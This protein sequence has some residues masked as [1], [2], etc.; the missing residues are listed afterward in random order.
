MKT[1][2]SLAAIWFATIS[3]SCTNTMSVTKRNNEVQVRNF[4]YGPHRQH[5]AE[6]NIPENIND[7]PPIVL[8]HGGSWVQG[9]KWMLRPVAKML[10]KQG[11]TTINIDYRLATKK[12][13][14]YDQF[15]DVRLAIAKSKKF[16]GVSDSIKVTLL[17]ES[18]GAQM[19]MMY[20]YKN[21]S[22]IGKIISL[23]G[24]T[25]LAD[26]AYSTTIKKVRAM[27]VL[28]KVTGERLDTKNIPQVYKDLSPYA[29][30]G[31]VPTLMIHG[32]WDMFVNI[33]QAYKLEKELVAKNVPHKLVVIEKAGHVSRL[34]PSVRKTIIYP[35]IIKWLN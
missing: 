5:K 12:I 34:I 20:G 4:S 22:E 19:S 7:K 32:T 3:A 11:F 17:G 35:E 16:L 27:P 6:I 31:D 23:S 26:V 28:K 21:P 33:R 25:D 29:N 24:P 13:C 1:L 30:V 2:Y 10:N 14:N 18:A 9:G 15:D 8:I